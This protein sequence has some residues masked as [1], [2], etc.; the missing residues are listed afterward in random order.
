MKSSISW[1]ITLYSPLQA[2]GRFGGIC[3]LHFQG[4]KISQA[5]NQLAASRHLLHVGFLLGLLFESEDVGY[6]FPPKRRLTFS[7]LHGVISQK[8]EYFSLIIIYLLSRD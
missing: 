8:I 7:R 6:T 2:N 5:R 3:R 1:D 4:R